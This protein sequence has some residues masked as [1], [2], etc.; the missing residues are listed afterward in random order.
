MQGLDICNALSL[1]SNVSAKSGRELV[2]CT[3]GLQLVCIVALYNCAK[4]HRL[5]EG[6]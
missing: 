6:Y 2:A 1:H 3:C 5:D 4:L